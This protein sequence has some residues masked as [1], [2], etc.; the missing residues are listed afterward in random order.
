MSV[1]VW[2]LRY[3]AT[4]A[5]VP[6]GAEGPYVRADFLAQVQT[7][8]ELA[9][10]EVEMDRAQKLIE[11]EALRRRSRVAT[12]AARARAAMP[13]TGRDNLTLRSPRVK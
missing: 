8:R 5:E 11:D 9:R 2:Y 3:N 7:Q 6:V 4:L 10:I 12:A 13:S 1:W